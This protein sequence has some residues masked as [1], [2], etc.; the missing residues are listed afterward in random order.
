MSAFYLVVLHA[1]RAMNPTL[2]LVCRPTDRQHSRWCRNR[3]INTVNIQQRYTFDGGGASPID[4]L[5]RRKAVMNAATTQ[6][7]VETEQRPSTVYAT[8]ARR[9]PCAQCH[10]A[11]CKALRAAPI[12]PPIDIFGYFADTDRITAMVLY[13]DTDTD[14]DVDV[15]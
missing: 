15:E 1:A 10:S 9:R 11:Y 2:Q 5:T 3:P 4:G 8:T 14:M 12:Y 7:A 6:H 13:V